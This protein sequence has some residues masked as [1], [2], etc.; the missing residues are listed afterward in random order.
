MSWGSGSWSGRYP[1]FFACPSIYQ[2]F[3][4]RKTEKPKPAPRLTGRTSART[5]SGSAC[6]TVSSALRLWCFGRVACGRRIRLFD[7]PGWHGWFRGGKWEQES[8]PARFAVQRAC[9]GGKRGWSPETDQGSRNHRRNHRFPRSRVDAV[10][11]MHSGST[12]GYKKGG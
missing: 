5:A 6:S 11:F 3:S 10:L 7:G 9:R 12:P 4:S 1:V 8:C 2:V